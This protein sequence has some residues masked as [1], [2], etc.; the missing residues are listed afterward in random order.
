MFSVVPSRKISTKKIDMKRVAKSGMQSLLRFPTRQRILSSF[1]NRFWFAPQDVLLRSVEANILQTVVMKHPILDVGIG[2]GGIAPLLYS[3]RLIIDHGFDIDPSGLGTAKASKKYKKVSQDNAEHMSFKN[4][5]F[6]TVICNSAC[7]HITKDAQA[8]KE[9]G[10]VL[11]KDGVLYLTVPSAFLPKMILDFEKSSGNTTPQSAL[12]KFNERVAHKHYHS[13]AEWKTMLSKAGLTIVGSTYYFPRE[14]TR[15]YY[16][17]MKWSIT[18]VWGRE[19][20]S[21]IGQSRFT[22]Y[23][24]RQWVIWCLK[25]TVLTSAYAQAFQA[26]DE[27]GM[28]FLMAKKG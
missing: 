17:F 9:M 8:V 6:A 26:S 7:E 18:R 27:G 15:A 3:K 28:L 21:W 4:N 22:P 20:W 23:I 12:K 10:R 5:S 16:R 1:L 25:T 13:L 11:K 19:M 24:P 2:D 14:T